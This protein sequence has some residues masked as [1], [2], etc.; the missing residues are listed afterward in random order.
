VRGEPFRVIGYLGADALSV[1]GAVEQGTLVVSVAPAVEGE[2][3]FLEATD[4]RIAA[5]MRTAWRYA[6]T[7]NGPKRRAAS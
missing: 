6:P 1:T 2:G 3:R 7:R 4:A 5:I